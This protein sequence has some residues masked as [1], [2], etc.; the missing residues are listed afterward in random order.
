MGRPSEENQAPEFP[1]GLQWLNTPRPLTLSELRGRVVVL[2]FW[3]FFSINCHQTSIQL[4]HLQDRFG[5]AIVVIGVH[6]AKFTAEKQI[7]NVR[8]AV[9]RQGI[10]Q[11][12]VNDSDF[13][14]W[15]Q[16]G[17]KSWP[18]L[19]L[20]D[21]AGQLVLTEPGEIRTDDLGQQIAQL[22]DDFKVQG[23][24]ECSP[25]DLTPESPPDR[26]GPL[27]YPSKLLATPTGRLFIADTGN[28]R[29]FDCR[30]SE[31]RSS[32]QVNQVFGNGEPVLLDGRGLEASFNSPRGLALLDDKLH[33]ADTDN[34]CIR[35]IDLDT[36]DVTTAAGTG[37]MGQGV[38]NISGLPTDVP[39]RSP[40]ALLAAD[41]ILFIAMAGNHQVWALADREIGPFA[42]TGRQALID[43]PRDQA[44][45]SQPSDLAL[46][47]DCLFVVDPEASAVR[48][49]TLEVSPRV[50]T[51]IGQ[52][53][54]E[55][56]DIDGVGEQVRLQNPTGLL[57]DE[58]YLYAAD[59]YNHKIK[60]LDPATGQVETLIGSG[61]RSGQDGDFETAGFCEP[62]GLSGGDG[63]LFI[64]DTNNHVIRVADLS[65]RTLNTL[66]LHIG[67]ALLRSLA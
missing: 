33:V 35:A 16:Y 55:F 49:I 23:N 57:F 47:H 67:D 64:A 50:F 43:G 40:W 2:E 56:G 9:L 10:R 54:F 60:R 65:T 41:G 5:D 39:L 59:T 62:Q 63:W 14:V 32:A 46:G 66:S 36:G 22:L 31:D 6:S 51:L 44:C 21:P 38:I 42:G 13:L 30:L 12:V 48:G 34:H 11:P 17:V 27:R 3:A 28:H 19:A 45:F 53:L 25:L 26:A 1:E 7:E 20:I 8:E 29:V 15:T 24:G 37:T 4:Q 58:R 52:G 61:E 18:T